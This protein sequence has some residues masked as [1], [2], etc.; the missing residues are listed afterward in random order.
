M[1]HFTSTGERWRRRGGVVEV[2]LSPAM[3]KALGVARFIQ[4]PARGTYAKAGE[5]LGAV[6]GTLTAAE[7][8]APC[9]GRV[10][11]TAAPDAGISGWLVGIVPA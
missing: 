9:N 7:F 8:Y 3:Q 4:L 5:Y 6:E 11:W 2:G 10:V 1:E